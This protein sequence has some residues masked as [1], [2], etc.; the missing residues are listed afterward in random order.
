MHGKNLHLLSTST[1]LQAF[2]VLF[3]FVRNAENTIQCL[4]ISKEEF[5]GGDS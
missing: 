2:N 3:I 1:N 4:R 5:L